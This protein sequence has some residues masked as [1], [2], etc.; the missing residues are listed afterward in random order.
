MNEI[1]VLYQSDNNYAVYMGVSI[2]SLLENNKEVLT[3][4]YIINDGISAIR[5]KEI[6]SL[7]NQYTATVTFIE[8]EDILN[9]SYGQRFPVYQGGRKNNHSFMKLFL[10][11]VLPENVE[12][13]LYID[14]DTVVTGEL[15]SLFEMEM[16]DC[17]IGMSLDS[18]V[19]K[20]K[21][22][23]G[24]NINDYYFNSGVILFNLINWKKGNCSKRV[25]EHAC[26]KRT[27]GTVDQDILNVEFKDNILVLPLEYNLQPLHLDYSTKLY[28]KN[29]KHS[30][31]SY[32]SP[33]EIEMAV[34]SPR[35]IHFLRY[36]GESPWDKNNCHPAKDKFDFYLDL[37]PWKEMKKG[38]RHKNIIF[39]MEKF[40]YIVLPKSIFLFLFS[41]IHTHKI[42]SENKKVSQ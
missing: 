9:S 20:S 41:N 32:Y 31:G 37:T 28:Y 26:S 24:F 36:I 1:N 5:I 7:I 30:Q 22:S 16:G 15:L 25:L 8:A 2:C 17:P 19:V 6:R 39:H 23:I 42:I 18:L 11:T 33:T 21:T 38:K 35:I 34:D 4:V 12:R 40:L 10:D 14:C 27:Y 13:I 29:Y 3:N